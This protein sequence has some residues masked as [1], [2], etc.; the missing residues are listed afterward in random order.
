LVH[1]S[2]GGVDHSARHLAAAYGARLIAVVSTPDKDEIAKTAGQT[3]SSLS[4]R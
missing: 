3:R 2:A 1:G 4:L